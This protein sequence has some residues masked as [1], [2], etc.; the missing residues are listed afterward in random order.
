MNT[1]LEQLE[2][3]LQSLFEQ[4]DL[5]DSRATFDIGVEFGRL[6]Q[7]QNIQNYNYAFWDKRDEENRSKKSIDA[8]VGAI[9]QF[10][11]KLV[12]DSIRD[13]ISRYGSWTISNGYLP[14]EFDEFDLDTCDKYCVQI[15]R[16]DR[17]QYGDDFECMFKVVGKLAKSF[18][19]HNICEQFEVLV[20]NASGE[21]QRSISDTEK[22]SSVVSFLTWRVRNS[23]D[24]DPEQYRDFLHVISKEFL[25]LQLAA[26]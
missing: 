2:S 12:E 1:N 20:S 13:H 23:N 4:G 22:V 24:W 25:L 5:R 8:A 17:S 10:L 11:L 18:N 16:V 7:Q 9:E 14:S 6:L 15:A 3:K 26:A 19:R 21:E